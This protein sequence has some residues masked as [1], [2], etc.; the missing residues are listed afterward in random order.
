MKSKLLSATFW[1]TAWA[2]AAH[3][4]GI[5][6]ILPSPGAVG[7]TFLILA[8]ESRFWLTAGYSLG[9]VLAGFTAGVVIGTALAILT[10]V[11]KIM[12]AILSPAIRI[13]RAAPVASFIILILLWATRA[14][15]PGIIAM[16]MVIPVVWGALV[17]AIEA[18][19]SNLLEMASAYRFGRA[20]TL[21]LIYLPS[22]MPQFLSSCLTAQGLAWKSGIAAEVICLP[23]LA[24][25]TEIYHS[26]IYLETPAL[27]VW[28][29]LVVI[30]SLLLE[31]AFRLLLT[32]ISRDKSIK[33]L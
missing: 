12:D 2:I 14:S 5:E 11:S 23:R 20:K 16:L 9:R 30:L 13:I 22:V 32:A 4:V 25:G 24:A 21:K 19:D 17:T 3:V 10:S 7:R 33:T 15:V 28:T 29:A 6:L 26:R 31:K 18:T 27:F 8:S 1:L